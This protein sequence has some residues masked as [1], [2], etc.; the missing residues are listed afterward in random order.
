MIKDAQHNGWPPTGRCPGSRPPTLPTPSGLLLSM[1]PHGVWYCFGQQCWLCSL[2]A[3]CAAWQLEKQKGPWLWVSTAQQQLK[4][5]CAISTIF[6]TNPKHGTVSIQ[7]NELYPS[8][9]STCAVWLW[10]T[11]GCCSVWSL[12][13]QSCCHVYQLSILVL[14]HHALPVMG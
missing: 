1:M 12:F 7:E 5:P 4:D 8:W 2:P 13:W 3:P 10:S 9:T 6:M 14:W 11:A